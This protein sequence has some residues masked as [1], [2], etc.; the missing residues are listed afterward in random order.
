MASPDLQDSVFETI[1]PSGLLARL[2]AYWRRLVPAGLPGRQHVDP[3]E[4]GATLLP[5]I[6]LADV[7]DDGRRFRWRLIGTHIVNHAASDDTGRDLDATIAPAMRETIIGHYR[8]TMRTRHPLC[9]RS[10]FVGRDRRVY[11]YER[12]LMPLA[13]DGSA[14][15]MILGGAVFGRLSDGA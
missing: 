10:K 1:E 11:R 2:V 4:I 13:A 7:L 14:I 12:V 15:D 8:E 6:F 3:V 5:H 9:H